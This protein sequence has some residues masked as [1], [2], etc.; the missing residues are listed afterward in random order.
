M[1]TQAE[2]L[3]TDASELIELGTEADWLE[4]RRQGI[5]ASEAAAVLGVSPYA[6]PI[7][8]YADKLGLVE[9]DAETSEAVAWG[10][11]LQPAIVGRYRSVTGRA[12]WEVPAYTLRRSRVHP[13]MVATL[14]ALTAID[15]PRVP[16]EVKNVGSYRAKDWTEEPPL[17][18]QVQAQHQMAVLGSERAS[19]AALIGGNRFVFCDVARNDRF[20]AALIEQLRVFWERLCAKEPPDVDG[21]RASQE[22]LRKLYPRETAG[23]VVNLPPEAVE[24]DQLAQ[25]ARESERTAK[26][27]VSEYENKIKAAI[28]E[29]E[30]G[31]LQTGA[32]YEWKASER[33][34]YTVAP[35]ITR[36]LRRKGGV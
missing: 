15:G 16:L 32:R 9:P 35:T 2:L 28:G 12:T 13:F 10:L 1:P 30:V 24:W 23:L 33:K 34:G 14:D 7:S 31:Y 21:S 11:I 27:V 18:V 17:W 3:T 5:G 22:L 29:A 19:V 4:A 26:K 8:L 20:I 6:T 36:T 25:V